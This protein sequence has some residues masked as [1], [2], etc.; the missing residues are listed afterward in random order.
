MRLLENANEKLMRSYSEQKKVMGRPVGEL[1]RY[2]AM[3]VVGIAMCISRD[4]PPPCVR[5]ISRLDY[6]NANLR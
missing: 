6:F 1:V 4:D 2:I 5:E 3:P